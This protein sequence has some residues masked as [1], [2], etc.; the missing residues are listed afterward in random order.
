ML[1]ART[2][3]LRDVFR[4]RGREHEDDVV[5]RLFQ[6]FQQRVE[7]G[8]GDLVSF[9]ENVDLE[10][11]AGGLVARAFTQFANFVD[12]AVGGRVNLDDVD[13]VAGADFSAGL[14]DAA[15]L[16]RGLVLRAAVQGSGQDAGDRR[17][18]DTSVAA[19]DVAVRGAAL[20]QRVLQCTGDVLLPD[21]LGK[22]LGTYLR[23]RTV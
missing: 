21:D 17:L 8:V 3:R 22:F 7:S 16:G 23:A 18:A 5:G 4:L 2:D 13:C 15:R 19:K 6:S 20:F 10:A 14:T 1:A 12:A 9:V 11:V